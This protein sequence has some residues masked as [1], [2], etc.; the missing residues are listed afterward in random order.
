MKNI[1][2]LIKNQIKFEM[3]VDNEEIILDD[4][5]KCKLY[6]ICAKN[7]KIYW[8]WYLRDKYDLPLFANHIKYSSLMEDIIALNIWEHNCITK[9]YA[10]IKH[11]LDLILDECLLENKILSSKWWIRFFKKRKFK[12]VY[13]KVLISTLGRRNYVEL[14]Q[15][16]YELSLEKDQHSFPGFE[17]NTI[18]IAI[19]RGH[20]AFLQWLWGKRKFIKFEVLPYYIHDANLCVSSISLDWLYQRRKIIPFNFTSTMLI[21]VINSDCSTDIIKWWWNKREEFSLTIPPLAVCSLSPEIKNLIEDEVE[22]LVMY[23]AK[24]KKFNECYICLEDKEDMR[25]IHL[26]CGHTYHQDCIES[27]IV[28]SNVCPLCKSEIQFKKIFRDQL[29]IELFWKAI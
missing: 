9:D 26:Q 7:N 12:I 29:W 22:I 19:Q 10:N 21:D 25:G 23:E 24:L 2:E 13:D 1:E 16:L 18:S 27:W 11:H 15:V 28:I 4:E 20:V 8:W 17:F 6:F 14:L 5:T 3:L